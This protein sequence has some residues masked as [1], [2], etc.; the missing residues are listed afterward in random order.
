MALLL[1]VG[2]GERQHIHLDDILQERGEM[3]GSAHEGEGEEKG[4]TIG[5]EGK[6]TCDCASR[7]ASLVW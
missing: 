1:E 7:L 5:G 2:H 6:F 3:K 4:G